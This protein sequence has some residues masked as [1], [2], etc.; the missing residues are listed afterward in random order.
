M[1]SISVRFQNPWLLLLLIPAPDT[2]RLGD[3]YIFIKSLP[4]GNVDLKQKEGGI[5]ADASVLTFPFKIR[6]WK[7]GD[8]FRP[9][10][11]S[12]RKKLSDLFTDLKWDLE[13]K[14]RALVAVA[15]GID[16]SHI[17]A[18]LGVRP[19]DRFKVKERTKTITNGPTRR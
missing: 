10:G 12:G 2:Y 4:A 7:S 5:F 11:M 14:R 17:A 1:S 16:E 15:P 18:V 19:D 6:R 13:Q 9:L 8:W 3:S